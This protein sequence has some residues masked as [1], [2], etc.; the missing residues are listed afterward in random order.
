VQT[1]AP[2]RRVLDFRPAPCASV[3]L[4]RAS[5]SSVRLEIIRPTLGVVVRPF[6]VATYYGLG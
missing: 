2:T 6:S 3:P 5:A 1:S 4:T